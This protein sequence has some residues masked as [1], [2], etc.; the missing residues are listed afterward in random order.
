MERA[1]RLL[2]KNLL[3]KTATDS[4]KEKDREYSRKYGRKWAKSEKGILKAKRGG[5]RSTIKHIR[6]PTPS[7][8]RTHLKKIII[9][10][11]EERYRQEIDDVP[12][13]N[14]MKLRIEACLLLSHQWRQDIT[15]RG[16]KCQATEHTKI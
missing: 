6:H 2:L 9:M 1:T 4:K 7:K 8:V 3:D 14:D 15:S 13:W 16:E 10:L 5:I 12:F 11:E